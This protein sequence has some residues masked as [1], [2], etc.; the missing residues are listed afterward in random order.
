MN[1]L[2]IILI[3]IL[4]GVL[5]AGCVSTPPAQVQPTVQ[6]TA[7][8]PATITLNGAGATFPYPLISKWSSEHSKINPN[9]QINYQSVGSGAG[10]QQITAK[11]VDFGASDAP[12]SEQV[13]KNLTGI[14]QIPET[15]GAV[16]VAYNL[17]GIQKGVNLSGDVIADIF[18]GKITKWNDPRIVSLNPDIQFPP[19]DII[20][21]HRSDGSGTTFVFTD[22][23]S[24]VSPDWKSQVGKGTSV[25]WPV[26]LGGKGNEGVAGILSQN[27]YAIGYVELIYAKAQNNISYSYIKNKAGIFIEPTLETTASAVAGAVPT[28]PAGDASWSSVSVVNAPGDNSYPISSFTYLLV[29]KNQ[30]ELTKGK[31]LAEFLWWAVHDGQSYSS[32]LQYVTLPKEVVSL[33]EKTI[34]LM[35]YNG[36]P[37]I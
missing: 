27:P 26:G 3:L 14:L 8:P 35:N 32:D 5:V 33:N 36:Q 9:I 6:T 13:Y 29:Y 10:I 2:K 25:N 19:K 37:L 15:I 34:K 16:V 28:L 30:A 24:A 7:Q 4:A 21:A 20:V 18:L 1:R 17:P 11:T 22:Y 31:A 23:L 12:L